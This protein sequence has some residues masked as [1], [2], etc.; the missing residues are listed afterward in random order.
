MSMARRH[1]LRFGT[2][3][4]AL[5]A[6]VPMARSDTYPSRPLRWIVGFPPGGAVDVTARLVGQ[7]LAER[8]GQPV[9]VENKPGSAN[10]LAVQAV[11]NSAPD[12]YTLL[13]VTTA[14]A[15][16][17]SLYERLAFDFLRDIA[18]V[19]GLVRLPLVMEVSPSFPVRTV[20]EFISYAKLRPGAI[21]LASSGI[22][23]A[24]HL[25]GELFKTMTGTEMI[26]VS[27]RGE[28]PAIT[29]I[30]GGRV[31]VMFG[32]IV[33]SIDA[34]RAGKLRAL[35]VTTARRQDVLPDVPTVSEFVPGYEVSAW[36]G[37]GVPKNTPKEI[38]V[39]LNSEISAALAHPRVVARLQELGITPMPFTPA[40]FAMHLEAEMVRW[41]KIVQSLG[42]KVR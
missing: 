24:P 12:G 30:M 2:A 1:F 18:P 22:G 27:Y 5:L 29:D 9:I 14:S 6:T 38:V 3:T 36:Y 39:K 20:D 7:V 28:P 10:N 13:L 21:K 25:A 16:N 31:E 11:V 19:A 41:G 32:S 33:T 15:I 40:E 4:A 34:I 26:H 17:A 37:V 8:L 23:T 42:L 35:A